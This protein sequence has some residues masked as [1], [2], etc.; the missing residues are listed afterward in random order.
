MTEY[1]IAITRITHHGSFGSE[2]SAPESFHFCCADRNVALQL[3]SDN[4]RSDAKW[5][6]ETREVRVVG[7]WVVEGRATV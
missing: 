2:R 7:A 4:M 6:E 3:V 5:Y 1:Q